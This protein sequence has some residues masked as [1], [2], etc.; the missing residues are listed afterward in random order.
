V[1]DANLA[2]GS[3]R[4]WENPFDYT[5]ERTYFWNPSGFVVSH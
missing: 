2:M 1:L 5:W 3:N 4:R